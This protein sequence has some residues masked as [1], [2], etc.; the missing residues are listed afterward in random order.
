MTRTKSN[1]AYC[2]ELFDA[3]TLIKQLELPDTIATLDP[4]LMKLQNSPVFHEVLEATEKELQVLVWRNSPPLM[5]GERIMD[6]PNT[7]PVMELRQG[8]ADIRDKISQLESEKKNKEKELIRL[9]ADQFRTL[10]NAIPD[11]YKQQ[12]FEEILKIQRLDNVIVNVTFLG[13]SID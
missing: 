2:Q 5:K 3:L 4:S 10:L 1:L 13:Y 8:L 12:F 9:Y 7:D 11:C 6:A